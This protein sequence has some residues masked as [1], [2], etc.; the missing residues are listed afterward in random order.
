VKLDWIW[1]ASLSLVASA[2]IFTGLV[3]AVHLTSPGFRAFVAGYD[4][5]ASI[6]LL[7]E[8]VGQ[9]QRAP[10]STTSFSR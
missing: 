2:L 1:I 10:S 7:L 4:S 8:K 3:M 6:S 9:V 5:A